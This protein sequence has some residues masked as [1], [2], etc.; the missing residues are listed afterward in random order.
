MWITDGKVDHIIEKADTV[1]AGWQKG[2]SKGKPAADKMW[3]TNGKRDI[4]INKNS[5][6]PTGWRLG[7]S[8]K[9]VVGAGS[10]RSK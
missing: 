9:S 1:P 4:Y 2:R 5:A 7:R 6:I 3:I 8:E 10:T